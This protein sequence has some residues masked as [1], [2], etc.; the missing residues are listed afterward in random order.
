VEA[1]ADAEEDPLSPESP[2][3]SGNWPPTSADLYKRGPAAKTRNYYDYD[4]PEMIECPQC[5]W[6]GSGAEG[7]GEYY[8]EL[9]D[10]S[11]PRCDK[12]LLIISYPTIEETKAAAAAGNPR[13]LEAMHGVERREKFLR[14]FEARKLRSPEQLPD[15]E[16]ESLEFLWDEE[17][18]GEDERLTVIRFG[19][20]VVWSEPEVWEGVDRFDAV[21]ALLK[22][23]YGSRFRS[24][25]PT[26]QSELYLYGDI[27]GRV[28]VD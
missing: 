12:M 9:F 14:L 20:R 19:D 4:E 18:R 1:Y 22:E 8:R 24:L 27:G 16:G 23:R 11:C 25:A 28:D 17:V 7:S 21:K 15:L 26:E 13:A 2:F 3:E 5:R 6:V 10:V